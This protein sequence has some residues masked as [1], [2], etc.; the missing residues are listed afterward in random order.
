MSL[1]ALCFYLPQFHPIPE[2]DDW[3]GP[4]FTEWTNVARTRPRFH[5]HHQPQIPA[6][7]GFYDLRLEETRIAQATLAAKY[8]IHGFVYYHY[9]FGGKR[10]LNRPLDEVLSTKKPDFP[11]CLCWANETWTRAWDG[12]ERAILIKQEYSFDNHRAHIEWLLTTCRDDRYIKIDG[13]PLFII[14]RPLDIPDLKMMI[15]LWRS[16]AKLAGFEGIYLCAARTGFAADEKSMQLMSLF[17]AVVDFQPNARDF[18]A[19]RDALTWGFGILKKYLP[20]SL[21]QVLKTRGAGN[22]RINYHDMVQGLVRKPWF[23][24]RTFPCVFPSWDN[25]ARR[26]TATI[27][28]ND[29]PAHYEQWLRSGVGRVKNYPQNEQFVFINAWNEWAEGCHL[30]PDTTHGHKFLEA[31]QRVLTECER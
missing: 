20:D 15:D 3:W 9:W 14:Y 13:R 26:A 28:Q 17:D 18:P 21:Y 19:A 4:G 27:I 29:E 31:T 2:N 11:F 8:G 1:K 6:D 12:R 5:G 16:E 10:L 24:Q 23:N 25:S 7:L 22:K 30:E